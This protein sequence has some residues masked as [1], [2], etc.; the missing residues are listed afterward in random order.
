[1]SE[2]GSIKPETLPDLRLPKGDIPVEISIINTTCDIV[3]PSGGFVKPVLQG[4]PYLN[5]PT[6]AFYIKHPSGRAI[7][8]DLG[9]RKD[10]WNFAPPVFAT[11]KKIIPGLKID[12]SVEEILQDN[13]VNLH[14]MEAAIIS[15]WH[16]DHFGAPA[17]LPKS[18]D[19]IVGPG[20]KENF[21]PGYPTK[22]DAIMLDEDFEGRNVRE[23]KFSS[24]FKIGKFE[25][26]DYFGDGS[27][28][29]LNVPGHAIGHISGLARTTKDTFCFLGGDV[30]HF[31]GMFRPTQ[32]APMPEQIPT[33]VPLDTSRFNIP[34]PCSMFTAC[35]PV[36]GKERT[37]PFYEVT[38]EEGSWY[39]D[40]PVAQA[41]IMSLAEFDAH[42]DV[43]VC[44]AHDDAL[45]SL[46]PFFPK[47]TL[48]DWK[49]QGWKP[50][51]HWLFLNNLPI[52]GK[53]ARGWIAPGLMKDGKRM[54]EWEEYQP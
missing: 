42:P 26:H 25:A 33:G 51:S 11:I 28:Y 2:Q 20:F 47:S 46:V 1:M 22:K 8:F 12:K 44:I 45:L 34:C 52:D 21:M 37:T 40:P 19:L 38:R 7:M 6:F 35:H 17:N 36:K 24:D 31:G 32:F 53:E 13:G 5:L 14:K 41:S 4:H 27:F 18:I 48:N 49:A 16:W 54:K 3:C 43:F 30:C 50:N 29:I 23:I 9:S 15:H 10:Y 39:L